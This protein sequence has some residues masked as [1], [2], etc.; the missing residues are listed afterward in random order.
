MKQL[1]NLRIQSK[2]KNESDALNV[3]ML[4]KINNPPDVSERLGPILLTIP[5]TANGNSWLKRVAAKILY[6]V[7]LRDYNRPDTTAPIKIRSTM[8][9]VMFTGSVIHVTIAGTQPTTLTM[10]RTNPLSTNVRL[11]NKV[12]NDAVDY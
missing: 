4:L 9:R 8:N 11:V 5:L 7:V 3:T 10:T 2:Q 12:R 6:R 1:P